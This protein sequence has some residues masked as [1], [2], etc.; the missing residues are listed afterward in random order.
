[1]FGTRGNLS[2][3]FREAISETIFYAVKGMYFG[4]FWRDDSAGHVNNVSASHVMQTDIQVTSALSGSNILTFGV[5]GNVD[6]VHS[7]LFG[8]HQGYGY[9]AY[10]QD[11]MKLTSAISLTAGARYDFQK[12]SV[13]AGAGRLSPKI[14]ITASLSRETVLR[15]S[16]G[17]GFRYPSIGELFI[18][19]ATNVSQLV[20]LPNIHLR[21]ETSLT[22]EV[23]I[24]APVA[25]SVS[26]DAALFW[27]EFND[28]IE[29]GVKIKN[30]PAS[31][32]DTV[33]TDRAVVEFENVTR[34]RIQGA[35]IGARASW[36]QRRISAEFGYTVLW[37]EDVGQNTVLKFRPRHIVT[38]SASVSWEDLK[39]SADYRFIS[40]IDRIDDQLVQLA[41]I[42]HGD[43]RVPIHTV[44]IRGSSMLGAQIGR[45]HV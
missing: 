25:E 9:A 35:E 7:N 6:E 22:A 11:E 16:L 29:P 14:G 31:P 8:D 27:N 26:M 38:T 39:L 30:V 20:I 1:M 3:G 10:L 28:L 12:A 34:A 21:P 40:R 19:S 17:A 41:P 44:D 24:A 18:S 15:A 4:N 2:L 36:W 32:S 33:G 43:A 37:P 13:L 23:G 5:A 45:A 42:V